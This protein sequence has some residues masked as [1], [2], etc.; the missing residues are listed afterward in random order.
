MRPVRRILALAMLVMLA[1]CGKDFDTRYAETQE[2]VKAKEV[3]IDKAQAKQAQ[4]EAGE[5]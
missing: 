1:A 4:K 2:K 5:R 3:R